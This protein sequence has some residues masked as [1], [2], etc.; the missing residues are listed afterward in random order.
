M[1]VDLS[2]LKRAEFPSCV[3]LGLRKLEENLMSHAPPLHIGQ[4]YRV[5]DYIF[6]PLLIIIRIKAVGPIEELIVVRELSQYLGKMM[7]SA[8]RNSLF[9]VL[10]QP[11]SNDPRT[12]H[13][14]RILSSLISLAI[15]THNVP[16]LEA[17]AVWMQQMCC[18]SVWCCDVIRGLVQDYFQL[19]PSSP[20][21]FA[22]AL[23]ALP[24]LAPLFTANLI[25]TLT[26]LYAKLGS[27]EVCERPPESLVVTIVYWLTQGGPG[28]LQGTATA[29]SSYPQLALA[30]LTHRL[31]GVSL[32]I[33]A[34]PPIATILKWCVEAPF[35]ENRQGIEAMKS[36]QRVVGA[37][38]LL[39]EGD[40]T[41]FDKVIPG[42]MSVNTS[43]EKPEL[44]SQLHLSLLQTLQSVPAMRATMTQKQVLCPKHVLSVIEAVIERIQM[45]GPDQDEAI[46]TSLDRLAQTILV[47]LHTHCLTGSPGSL[48]EM[49]NALHRLPTQNRLVATLLAKNENN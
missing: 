13:K 25:T 16:V 36:S 26:Q 30:P 48:T 1:S 43:C 8:T 15:T 32:P 41:K 10:F 42:K 6:K 45:C 34:V 28:S 39:T 22:R 44:F 3:R 4:K 7:D 24:A 17:S 37:Q 38:K 49:W 19:N 9:M 11:S 27:G 33:T 14:M 35:F 12:P 23:K 31:P 5:E 40:L 18:L 46:N 21:H 29:I 2:D 20:T 47:A